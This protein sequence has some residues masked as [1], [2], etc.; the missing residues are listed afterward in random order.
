MLVAVVVVRLQRQLL[1]ILRDELGQVDGLVVVGGLCG[2]DQA[3]P[4]HVVADGFALGGRELGGHGFVGEQAE[5]GFL[6]RQFA[7][8]TVDHADR[9][10]AVRLHQRMGQVEADQKLLHAQPAVYQVDFEGTLAQHAVAVF[11]L[12]RRDDLHL[13]AFV[14]EEIAE[15]L[16][17]A[18]RRSE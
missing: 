6:V 14:A 5:H 17:L 12:F 1:A 10:V 11:Q 16:V 9:A 7:A 3:G 2:R 13:V 18:L 4:R 15:E 8:E